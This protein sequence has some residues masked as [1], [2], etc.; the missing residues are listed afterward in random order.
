[1]KKHLAEDIRNILNVLNEYAFE[2]SKDSKQNDDQDDQTDVTPDDEEDVDDVLSSPAGLEKVV[3]NLNVQSLIDILD[4]PDDQ[5]DAFKGAIS[6]LKQDEPKPTPE[7]AMALAIG[8]NHLLASSP[9]DKNKVPGAIRSVSKA[10]DLTED[11]YWSHRFDTATGLKQTT[12]K[13]QQAAQAGPAAK[14]LASKILACLQAGSKGRGLDEGLEGVFSAVI[15]TVNLALA[16]D[17]SGLLHMLDAFE[18]KY[19]G[20]HYAFDKTHWDEL[21]GLLKK[22]ARALMQASSNR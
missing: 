7:Q 11:A 16:G 4:I 22:L 9:S 6:S 2:G 1:M 19:E 17:K 3:G 13:L 20:D 5:V 12:A 8:F 15:Y 14:E 21:I 10:T 18:E